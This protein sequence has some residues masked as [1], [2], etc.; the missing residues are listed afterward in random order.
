MSKLQAKLYPPIVFQQ[1]VHVIYTDGP[2]A[3]EIT[4]S[5]I[6]SDCETIKTGLLPNF[7]SVLSSEIIAIQEAIEICTKFQGKQAI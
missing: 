5:S 6:T 7:S 4:T 2:K 1:L 3:G